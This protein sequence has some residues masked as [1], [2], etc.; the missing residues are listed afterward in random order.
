MVSPY[1]SPDPDGPKY[2]EYNVQK[3]MRFKPF[4]VE[5]LCGHDTAVFYD[6]AR[7]EQVEEEVHVMRLYI[8]MTCVRTRHVYT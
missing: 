2:E 7:F 5:L 1:Y 4:R 3:M 8:R 6:L